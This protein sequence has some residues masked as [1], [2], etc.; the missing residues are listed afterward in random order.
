MAG[1]T[2]MV[3]SFPDAR[4]AFAAFLLCGA[5]AGL[6]QAPVSAPVSAPMPGLALNDPAERLSGYMRTLAGDPA[7]VVALNGAGRAAL[8]IGDVNGALGFYGRAAQAAPQNGA[9]KAG[10]AA[11]LVQLEQPRRALPLFAQAVQLGVPTAT[12]AADRGLAYD[13]IGDGASAQRDYAVALAASDTD[14]TRRRYALSLG[15]VGERDKALDLLDP[16]VRRRDPAGWR[17]RAFVMALTGD[18]AGAGSIVEAMMPSQSAAMAPFLGELARLSPAQKAAAVNFGDMPAAGVAGGAGTQLAARDPTPLPNPVRSP[19]P[20]FV[21]PAT[22]RQ[23]PAAAPLG[24]PAADTSPPRPAAAIVRPAPIVIATAAP[25][26][27]YAVTPLPPPAAAPP[28]AAPL[29]VTPAQVA[30]VVPQPVAPERVAVA[31][32]QLVVSAPVAPAAA[33]APLPA[34]ERTAAPSAPADEVRPG[35]SDALTSPSAAVFIGPPAPEPVPT[36]APASA[37]A[38]AAAPVPPLAVTPV[39]APPPPPLSSAPVRIATVALPPATIAAPPPDRLALAEAPPA[40]RAVPTAAVAEPGR[41]GP[42]RTVAKREIDEQRTRLAAP[43]EPAGKDGASSGTRAAKAKP[44]KHEDA[45]APSAKKAK[46]ADADDD[47]ATSRRPSR[48]EKTAADDDDKMTPSRSRPAKAA[49]R[50]GDAD[51]A[52]AKG[53]SGRSRSTEAKAASDDDDTASSTSSRTKSKRGKASDAAPEK[54]ATKPAAKQ[55]KAA[56]P[57]DGADRPARGGRVY[58]QVAGGANKDDMPKA[59]AQ[60]KRKA[61]GLL[62]DKTPSTTPLRFTNRLLVGPFKDADEAQRFVNK[63]AGRGMSG[64]IFTSAGGQKIEKVPTA[65]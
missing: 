34:P 23:T 51:P 24:P 53:K 38:S 47:R 52:P 25:T 14:E 12:I 1:A 56:D 65:R 22:A 39:P 15:I 32:P 46:D 60:V 30:A 64:S 33:P 57:D 10:L 55:G 43:D 20:V 58:V 19:P 49:D 5:A 62:K 29:R 44:G 26:R 16:L 48:G 2:M 40:R 31:A 37:A 41:V 61:P 42:F 35:V 3:L 8:E 50:S 6:A 21:P 17:A 7:N 11:A 36:P 4:R 54:P 27:G 18:T 28:S 9:A 13:L 63:L 45:V 59:W